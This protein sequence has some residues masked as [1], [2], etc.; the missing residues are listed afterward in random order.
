LKPDLV[1]PG[2]R[3]VSAEAAASYLAATYPARHVAGAGADAYMQLSGTSMAAGVVSGAVALL[4]EQKAKLTPRKVKTILQ[5]TSE[6]LAGEG[7]LASG[8]GSLNVIT[9]VRFTDATPKAAEINSLIGGELIQP[10]RIVTITNGDVRARSIVWGNSGL[11]LA[12][13]KRALADRSSSDFTVWGKSIVWGN[14]IVWGNSIVWGNADS[15]VWGNADSI[16]WGNADSIVWGNADS[17]V[18][19]NADSIVWGNADSIVWGNV[20]PGAHD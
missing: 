17:I 12:E 9:A 18:W 8:T 1:A 15:I 5:L 19:G 13:I 4:L 16:V 2:S 7:L 20:S 10:A 6:W 14:C 11:P 3:V